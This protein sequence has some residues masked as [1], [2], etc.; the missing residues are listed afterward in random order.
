MSKVQFWQKKIKSW[1][2]NQYNRPQSPILKRLLWACNY[3]DDKVLSVADIGCGLGY[4]STYFKQ[5]RTKPFEAMDYLGI[6]TFSESPFD[7]K[8]GKYLCK[9][10]HDV[11]TQDLEGRDHILSLGLI[12]WIEQEDFEHL[13]DLSKSRS[14]IHSFTEKKYDFSGLVYSL[15]RFLRKVLLGEPIPKK[16]ESKFVSQLCREKGLAFKILP[17][18]FLVRFIV[19]DNA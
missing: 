18:P 1:S 17:G 10:V 6:D 16:Y 19:S 9:E 12:D 13:L 7:Q 2:Q 3:W 4:F 15:Y 5:H 11:T 14:Y 8:Y